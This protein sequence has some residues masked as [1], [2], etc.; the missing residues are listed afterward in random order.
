MSFCIWFFLLIGNYFCLFSLNSFILGLFILVCSFFV[1]FLISIY[2]L[3]W[4]SLIFFLVY[5]GGLLV[6]FIYISSLNF[7]PV[8]Y[9]S[10][11]NVFSKIFFKINV[12]FFL[13]FCFIQVTW[14]FN[15]FS[16]N[17]SLD[18]NNFSL[19]L[20]NEV[21]VIFLISIGFLLLLVL[22][23]ITKLSFRNRGALRPFYG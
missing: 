21:E 12:L 20:F 10:N 4:Y 9:F 19:N 1:S 8:F 2:S 6:L 5:I 17:S 13:F 23:V 3:S 14:N 18:S 16:W 22:W 7:N 11:M 15:V